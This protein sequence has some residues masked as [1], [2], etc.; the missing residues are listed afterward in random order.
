[1]KRQLFDNSD[2]ISVCMLDNAGERS[3]GSL[4]GLSRFG[5]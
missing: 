5:T 3:V 2:Q 1:M 4:L